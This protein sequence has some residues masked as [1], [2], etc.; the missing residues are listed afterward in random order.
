MMSKALDMIYYYGN[1]HPLGNWVMRARWVICLSLPWWL[2][3][4]VKFSRKAEDGADGFRLE[5]RSRKY[6]VA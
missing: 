5:Q 4:I 6:G 2:Y 3:C 1:T